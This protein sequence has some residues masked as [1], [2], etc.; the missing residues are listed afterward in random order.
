MLRN[1]TRF[2]EMF[3]DDKLKLLDD[4]IDN[5]DEQKHIM[6]KLRIQVSFKSCVISRLQSFLKP[7]LRSKGSQTRDK[8]S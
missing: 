7:R 1:S 4:D 3:D 8:N 6:N 2:Q 5:A